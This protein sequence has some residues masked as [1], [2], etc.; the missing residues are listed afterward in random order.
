MAVVSLLERAPALWE[1]SNRHVLCD[2]RFPH[3]QASKTTDIMF[4]S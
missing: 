2:N 1:V 3:K 4:V